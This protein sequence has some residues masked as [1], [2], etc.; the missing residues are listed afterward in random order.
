[1]FQNK[2]QL[3]NGMKNVDFPVLKKLPNHLINCSMKN[4]EINSSSRRRFFKKDE[5]DFPGTMDVGY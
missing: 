2:E 3:N 4:T 1:M 5:F